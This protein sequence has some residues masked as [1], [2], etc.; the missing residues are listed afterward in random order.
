M[1]IL[2]KSKDDEN[3]LE[4]VLNMKLDE[5]IEQSGNMAAIYIDIS[6][7]FSRV[8]SGQCSA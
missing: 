1:L 8:K 3:I 4:F 2:K 7:Q 5:L 6:L